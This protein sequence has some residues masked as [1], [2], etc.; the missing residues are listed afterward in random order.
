MFSFQ[1][2]SGRGVKPILQPIF[3]DSLD[4]PRSRFIGRSLGGKGRKW[5]VTN[6]PEAPADRRNCAQTWWSAAPDEGLDEEL[7][8]TPVRVPKRGATLL[9]FAHRADL[10]AA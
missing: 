6:L 7:V 8:S 9:R 5:V 2:T 3:A 4:R 1:R 10:E